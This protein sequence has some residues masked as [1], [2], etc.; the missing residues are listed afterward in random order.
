MTDDALKILLLIICGMLAVTVLKNAGGAYSVQLVITLSVSAFA[1]IAVCMKPIADFVTSLASSAGID[2]KYL[3]II[4]KAL[5]IC[6]VGDFSSSV[7]KDCGESALAQ[8]S[9][10]VCKCSIILTAL[11]LYNDVYEMI[12]KI[13]ENV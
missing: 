4:L 12:I 11:P 9:E 10:L 3:K 5:G 1:F 7:C 2:D 6:I 8:N 13:W